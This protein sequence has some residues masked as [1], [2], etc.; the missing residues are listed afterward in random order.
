MS[1]DLRKFLNEDIG[2]GDITTEMFVPD[3]DGSADIVCEN[4]A[5]I[6]GL[7]EAGKIFKMLNAKCE[8]RVKDGARVKKGTAV[9]TVT[10][11]LKRIMTA[12]RTALNMMMRMSGIAT[13]VNDIVTECMSVNNNIKI[14]GTR[15]TTPGFRAY[16]K[17][18]IILGGGMPHR[19]GLYDMILVKD[20]HIKAAGG[21]MNIVNIIKHTQIDKRIEIEIENIDDAVMAANVAD[22]VMIDNACPAEAE[23]IAAAVRKAGKAMIEVSGNI[24]AENAAGYAKFADIISMG[25]LTHS[26]K[27]IHFSLNVR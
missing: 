16:E 9:M 13:A 12:E 2:T 25:S 3:V 17:K 23:R 24:T 10:G 19:Y 15:K 27:A 1:D 4:D 14:A 18:A 5:V 8:K 20:N 6:A 22:I 7:E 26:V 11:P 21:M